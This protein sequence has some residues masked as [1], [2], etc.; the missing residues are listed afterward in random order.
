M[1]TGSGKKQ[2]AKKVSL[3][4]RILPPSSSATYTTRAPFSS[5]NMRRIER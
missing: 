3:L 4:P 5:S 1:I 2:Q